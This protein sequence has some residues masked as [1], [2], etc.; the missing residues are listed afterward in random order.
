MPASGASTTRL[1][2]VTPPSVQL[3][4]RDLVTL[5][6]VRIRRMDIAAILKPWT[7]IVHE[8]APGIELFDVHTHIGQNDPDG[9]KQTPEQLLEGLRL[10]EARGAFVF[11]MHEPD[12]YPPAND[13]V[14]EAGRNSGGLLH[15]FCRVDPHDDAA[16]EAQRCLD[17]GACGI[18]L[19]PRAEQ[20]P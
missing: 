11:P 3:S 20:V 13:A 5:F 4:L 16:A 9:M 17:A 15:P 12:G 6:M 7:E 18:K 2:I 19:H 1:E 14:L 8:R 10:A